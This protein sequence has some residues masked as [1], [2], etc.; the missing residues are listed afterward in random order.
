MSL[1]GW[2][3]VHCECGNRYFQQVFQIAWHEQHGTTTKPDGFTCTGCGK[4]TDHARMIREVKQRNLQRKMDELRAES[5][6]I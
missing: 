4:R 1:Q 2:V 3:D 5:E 6:Q